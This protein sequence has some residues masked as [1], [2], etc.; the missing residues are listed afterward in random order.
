MRVAGAA[1][2]AL[3]EYEGAR[4]L[5]EVGAYAHGP[6]P[7]STR[8][9]RCASAL[10]GFCVRSS[11]S[12]PTSSPPGE[13]W[14]SVESSTPTPFS[15]LERDS[16]PPVPPAGAE[17]AIP[18]SSRLRFSHSPLRE[19]QIRCRPCCAV[20]LPAGGTPAGGAPAG[21]PR[22]EQPLPSGHRPAAP[23]D[24][25][26]IG[27]HRA[28]PRP[29][30]AS[31]RPVPRRGC[32]GPRRAGAA[33]A[34]R[35][36]G[37]HGRSR[38]TPD[39]RVRAR[40][41]Q[42]GDRRPPRNAWVEPPTHTIPGPPGTGRCDPPAR[43]GASASGTASWSRSGASGSIRTTLAMAEIATTQHARRAGEEPLDE[44]TTECVSRISQL[45]A[46]IRTLDP[47]WATS[48]NSMVAAGAESL[49]G[50][51]SF[52]TRPGR[53]DHHGLFRL[54]IG[55]RPVPI[56]QS[57]F[58]SPLPSAT[59]TAGFGPTSETLEP[60]ATVGGV[61]YAHYH[62][63]IDLAAPLGTPGPRRGERHGHRGGHAVG[64]GRWSSR[65]ATTTAM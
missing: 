62:N 52:S 43:D 50:Y 9:S 56:R 34:F 46:W 48:G 65:S 54:G 41:G 47:S 61:A 45:D 8:R 58:N 33:L 30:R 3:A 42:L 7:P 44:T 26:G 13:R 12:R 31:A 11:R 63:G 38:S 27:A 36:A 22:D 21:G 15:G 20:R 57:R 25:R 4:D 39:C 14:R 37:R 19:L 1:R 35:P 6:T 55:Q 40:V 18:P 23:R 51:S 59:L 17:L 49:V 53:S 32:P 28:Q 29:R 10:E 64:T 24:G 5:I 16:P 60:S 2:A